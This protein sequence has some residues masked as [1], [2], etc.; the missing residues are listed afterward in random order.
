MT[1]K[2][3]PAKNLESTIA[4]LATN[5]NIDSKNKIKILNEITDGINVCVDYIK[6]V[7]NYKICN[8]FLRESNSHDRDGFLDAQYAVERSDRLRKMAH[9]NMIR[10]VRELN[11][12]C[13]NEAKG[14]PICEEEY[15]KDRWT[16]SDFAVNLI[17]GLVQK[18]DEK[19][20][21]DKLVEKIESKQIYLEQTE[22]KLQKMA[23]TFG[24]K[25]NTNQNENDLE[26]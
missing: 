7:C 1:Y 15:F 18:Q 3:N 4:L 5:D 6:S 25:S 23:E 19:P 13:V 11:A 17:N 24:L 2:S 12:I 21:M 8:Q 9:D 26:R 14:I 10:K 22:E 16:M 20:T